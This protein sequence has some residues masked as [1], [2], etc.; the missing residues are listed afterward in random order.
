MR[1]AHGGTRLSTYSAKEHL[2]KC[3]S[4]TYC[5]KN[6]YT[7][8]W[9]FYAPESWRL[10]MCTSEGGQNNS[11]ACCHSMQRQ[12]RPAPPCS[13]TTAEWRAT[14]STVDALSISRVS[15]S[16]FALL[17]TIRACVNASLCVFTL[18]W[19]KTH[20]V[21]QAAASVNDVR[22]SCNSFCTVRNAF[23]PNWDRKRNDRTAWCVQRSA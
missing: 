8:L 5:I 11:W 9:V 7:E 13:P 22:G 3:A 1:T 2:R 17:T 20:T 23:M 18:H 19:A 4:D 15:C 21:S 10:N 12:R 6:N 14:V 16:V